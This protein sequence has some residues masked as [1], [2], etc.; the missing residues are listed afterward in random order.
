MR[1]YHKIHNIFK[2]NPETNN[3][4]FLLGQWSLPEFDFLQNNPWIFTEKVDGTNIR[5]IWDHEN[6]KIKFDGKTDK[7]QIPTKLFTKLTEMFTIE[8]MEK[9]FPQ[10]S[11]CLYGEGYG[12]GIQTGGKYRK[13]QS[14]VLFDVLVGKWWLQRQ[15]I[16]EISSNLNIDIVPIVGEGTLFDGIDLVKNGFNSKWG[17]FIAEGIVAKPK[18]ELFSRNGS[19]IVAKIKYKDF[20]LKG[21]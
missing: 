18:V 6:K 2:R 1:E 17:N 16:E 15:D 7:S 12:T 20:N 10:T 4:T 14:F 9:V 5:V 11:L 13:D 8:L 19:R 21:E 3:K